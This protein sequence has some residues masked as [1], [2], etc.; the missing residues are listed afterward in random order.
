MVVRLVIF[1]SDLKLSGVW[2]ILILIWCVVFVFLG[3]KPLRPHTNY[4]FNN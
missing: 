3:I 1:L 2:F 4:F